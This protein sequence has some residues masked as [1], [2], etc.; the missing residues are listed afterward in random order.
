MTRTEERFAALLHRESDLLERLI[1]V[2][3]KNLRG[4]FDRLLAELTENDQRR[5]HVL[6]QL[7]VEMAVAWEES[8]R[9]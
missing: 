9:E 4:E 5:T 6:R 2:A 8:C 3:G 7:D 1:E